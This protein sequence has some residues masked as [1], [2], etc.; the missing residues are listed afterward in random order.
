MNLE[1]EE[2]SFEHPLRAVRERRRAGGKGINVAANLHMLGIEA[3]AVALVGGA[4]GREFSEL[5]EREGRYVMRFVPG[6]NN[7]RTNI[8]ITSRRDGR[9]LKV[10]RQGGETSVG[11]LKRVRGALRKL[12]GAGDFLVLGGSLPPGAPANT[13]A[14]LIAEFR[15]RGCRVAL[16]SDLDA[17]REGVKACPDFIKLNREELERLSGRELRS[18]KQILGGM[19]SLLQ[20][21]CRLCLVTDGG[22]AAYLATR[23]CRFRG[24]PPRA[25]GSP[26]G[27]GDACL[28]GMMK[29][30]SAGALEEG[31]EVL[32][33]GFRLALACGS[34][35]A[36]MPDTEYF[37]R[38]VFEKVL[39]K[40]RVERLG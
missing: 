24:L 25:H 3:T 19:N 38:E 33:E 36:S 5:A 8:V 10:N 17:L 20:N 16:D 18:K 26:V 2:F 21:S 6:A 28:A 11:E 40:V 30:L 4:S 15:G 34:A 27:A 13:Y 12:L 39:G 29:M 37:S 1:V 23:D 31:E 35:A 22:S 14:D 9:H 7:T 32:R